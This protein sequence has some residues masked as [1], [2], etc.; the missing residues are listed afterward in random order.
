MAGELR[1]RSHRVSIAIE[2]L[3]QLADRQ[4]RRRMHNLRSNLRQRPQHV[5]ALQKIRPRQR[6][7]RL[8]TH[9]VVIE[10]NIEV[11]A[12][13]SPPW[14]IARPSTECF[15]GVQTSRSPRATVRSGLKADDAI[16]EIVTLKP[17]ARLRYQEEK[18]APG[19]RRAN[20][21]GSLG[22][23]LLGIDITP[24][25]DVNVGHDS[26]EEDPHGC[27][28]WTHQHRASRGSR[29]AC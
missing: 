5:G 18:R 20:S 26:A 22:D 24:D 27:V 29:P 11:H 16:D 2:A 4:S 9:D 13:R 14:C 28:Q 19:N 10:Q 7:R 3:P 21:A 15:D 1:I 25:G 8:R 6:H 17:T 12:A 23:V